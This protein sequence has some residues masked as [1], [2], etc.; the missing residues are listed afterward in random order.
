MNWLTS[1]V[2]IILPTPYFPELL[3]RGQASSCYRPFQRASSLKSPWRLAEPFSREAAWMPPLDLV[4][5]LSGT[6]WLSRD[7]AGSQNPSHFLHQ[8]PQMVCSVE[9][10]PRKGGIR[11]GREPPGAMCHQIVCPSVLLL[12]TDVL[13]TKSIQTVKEASSTCPRGSLVSTAPCSLIKPS[14]L[15]L[16][17]L[18]SS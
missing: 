3:V 17:E 11:K 18:E 7:S 4:S 5:P 14:F 9:H 2:E 10:K 16:V 8:S 6:R 12:L 13:L 15:S 1:S